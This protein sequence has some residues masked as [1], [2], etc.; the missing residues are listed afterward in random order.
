MLLFSWETVVLLPEF[1]SPHFFSRKTFHLTNGSPN[2][3]T[4]HLTTVMIHFTT[5]TK[6][7][8]IEPDHLM[9]HFT[10]AQTYSQNSGLSC[11]AKLRATCTKKDGTQKQLL[12]SIP[13][14]CTLDELKMPFKKINIIHSGIWGNKLR[15]SFTTWLLGYIPPTMTSNLWLC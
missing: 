15:S 12:L 13:S 4:D 3:H 7:H 5:I 6:S 1:P 14:F 8:K 2:K 11:G 9:T 10:I